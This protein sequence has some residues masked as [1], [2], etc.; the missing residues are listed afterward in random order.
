MGRTIGLQYKGTREY[1]DLDYLNIGA[2]SNYKHLQMI[3]DYMTKTQLSYMVTDDYKTAAYNEAGKYALDQV[4]DAANEYLLTSSGAPTIVTPWI[5]TGSA[6]VRGRNNHTKVAIV[7]IYDIKPRTLMP[8]IIPT[9]DDSQMTTADIPFRM[10]LEGMGDKM[11]VADVETQKSLIY[12]TATNTTAPSAIHDTVYN[13]ACYLPHLTI[14]DSSQFCSWFEVLNVHTIRLKPGDT[15]EYNWKL[16]KVEFMDG[17][18]PYIGSDV[19]ALNFT[20]F[21]VAEVQGEL[22]HKNELT[23]TTDFPQFVTNLLD[24]KKLKN[25]EVGTSECTVDVSVKFSLKVEVFD[26]E[27]FEPHHALRINAGN[28]QNNMTDSLYQAIHDMN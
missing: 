4:E 25:A 24:G 3:S 18:E 26:K 14:F 22:A 23:A 15:F 19:L 13:S 17:I 5:V 27:L 20:R 28:D 9:A 6:K 16:P 21:L 1:T 12:C 2:P 10:V 8:D 11:S 7:T